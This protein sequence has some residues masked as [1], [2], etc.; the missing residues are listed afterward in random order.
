MGLSS[1]KQV[2]QALCNW[3]N[4]SSWVSWSNE[5]IKGHVCCNGVATT[6]LP[7]SSL[8]LSLYSSIH[9]LFVFAIQCLASWQDL[10][11][12]G[13]SAVDKIYWILIK[14]RQSVS[15]LHYNLHWFFIFAQVLYAM[16]DQTLFGKQSHPVDD[17]SSII[18]TLK[19]KHTSWK[20]VEGTHW[21]TRF[22]HL[23]TYGAGKLTVK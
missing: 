19:H 1:V 6:G 20:H 16:I 2:C 12:I 9:C 11:K 17:T 14:L 13:Q 23:I 10:L 3:R 22:S 4:H 7:A 8:L 15:F 21:Q 5:E 18:A